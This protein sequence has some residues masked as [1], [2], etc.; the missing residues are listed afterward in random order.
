MNIEPKIVIPFLVA[1]LV[2]SACTRAKP[3]KSDAIDRAKPTPALLTSTV[4]AV[5]PKAIE[6]NEPEPPIADVAEAQPVEEKPAEVKPIDTQP[7]FEP[8]L[9]SVDGLI[10]ERLITAPEVERREPVAASSLFGAHDARVYAFVE[11]RN[12]SEEDKTL[13]VHFI[14]P[15]GQV[16]G[17]IEL[18]IPA[19]TPRW[20]T[21]AYT[22]NATK[23]GFWRVEIRSQDGT[24][25]GALPFEVEHGC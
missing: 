8:E 7:S 21:W 15:E 4:P 5:A 13:R 12:E 16:S 20:R 25:V 11:V 3:E 6:V 1:L 24:L 22:R 9:A 19:A 2:T 17:G 14:G 10:I 18:R 23:P